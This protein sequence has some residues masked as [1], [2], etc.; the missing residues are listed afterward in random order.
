MV[1]LFMVLTIILFVTVDYFIQRKKK[2]GLAA[3]PQLNKLSL[4]KIF[5]MLPTGVFLQP[6]FTWSKILDSGN[7]IVGIHPVLMGLIGEPDEIQMLH[8]SEEV[9]KGD[10][11]LK[12]RKGNKVLNVKSP[13]D[14]KISGL[15]EQILDDATWENI[16]QNWLY[17]LKPQNVASEIP[18]WFIAEKSQNWV[19][20]K[21]QQIKA[22]FMN[23]MPQTEMGITMADGG[24][25]PVG[26]LSQFD[27]KTWQK[28]E[29]EFIAIS[30]N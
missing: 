10:T 6:S 4:S 22:F 30:E 19:N 5:H 28:F 11:L 29:K 8:Q 23:T 3:Q 20:E 24:D 2:I 1:V 26:I 13:V 7:L 25:I 18:S 14:G 16:S 17:S 27:E 9:R 12:L 15:N 21:Y